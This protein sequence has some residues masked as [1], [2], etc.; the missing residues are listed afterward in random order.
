[1]RHFLVIDGT[2]SAS[3]EYDFSGHETQNKHYFF[4]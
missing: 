4:A 2:G 3:K 1:M